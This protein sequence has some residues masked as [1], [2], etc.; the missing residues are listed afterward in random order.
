MSDN[1]AKVSQTFNFEMANRDI[2]S[3]I[4]ESSNPENGNEVTGEERPVVSPQVKDLANKNQEDDFINGLI[5]G[6]NDGGLDDAGLNDAG[7]NDMIQEVKE[8][9]TKKIGSKTKD[10]MQE[11]IGWISAIIATAYVFL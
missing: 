9:N 1:A 2:Q 6:L 10:K 7:V 8:F 11:I 3:I 4:R 5:A